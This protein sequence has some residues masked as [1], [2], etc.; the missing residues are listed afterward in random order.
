[1]VMGKFGRAIKSGYKRVYGSRTL[2]EAGD[3]TYRQIMKPY[4]AVY[5]HKSVADAISQTK[6]EVNKIKDALNVERHSVEVGL[7]NHAGD[8]AGGSNPERGYLI[9]TRSANTKGRIPVAQSLITDAAAGV[10]KTLGELNENNAASGMGIVDITPN[11]DAGLLG[12]EHTRRGNQV[13]LTGLY[14][15]LRVV[16][17]RSYTADIKL[18]YTDAKNRAVFLNGARGKMY[19]VKT[20]CND[21]TVDDIRRDFLQPG[22]DSGVVDVSSTRNYDHLKDFEVV[23]S[24]TFRV[25]ADSTKGHDL[26]DAG[27]AHEI[28]T[29]SVTDGASIPPYKLNMPY[30]QERNKTVIRKSLKL[31]QRLKWR[32]PS[33]I[34]PY[35][36]RY[37]AVFVL[38]RGNT[39]TVTPDMVNSYGFSFRELS[40]PLDNTGVYIHGAF[41]WWFVDN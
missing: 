13:K 23:Y 38:D 36:V 33:D 15:D 27:T 10:S 5:G 16:L 37:F 12:S 22:E 29:T 31:G 32:E 14:M 18:G 24:R 20:H 40:M 34:N 7:D 4:T 9:D 41:K 26:N 17:P 8:E 19:I 11:I 6:R 30:A 1:M 21:I 2:G 28:L 3:V 35:N 25:S 39:G